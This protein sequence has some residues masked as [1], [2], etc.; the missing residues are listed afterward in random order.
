V[1]PISVLGFTV[2]NGRRA[3]LGLIV[4]PAKLRHLNLTS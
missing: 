3:A 1:E 2:V 4:D